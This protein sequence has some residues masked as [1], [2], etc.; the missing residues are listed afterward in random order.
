MALIQVGE[1]FFKCYT[2]IKYIFYIE[3]KNSQPDL[4]LMKTIKPKGLSTKC[5]SWLNRAIKSLYRRAS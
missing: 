3:P 4:D 5:S 1:L 2:E